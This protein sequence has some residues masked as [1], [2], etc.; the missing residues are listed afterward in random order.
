VAGEAGRRGSDAPV[1]D[2]DD[3]VVACVEIHGHIAIGVRGTSGR[4]RSEKNV[5]AG[6]TSKEYRSPELTDW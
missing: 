2:V 5:T 6:A 4:L 1:R 3:D